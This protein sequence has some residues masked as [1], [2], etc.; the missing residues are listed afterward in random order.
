MID[1]KLLREDPKPFYE[2]CRKRGFGKEEVD[3]FLRLDKE[4]R[5][6]LKEIN[7]LRHEKNEISK[8]ISETL[9]RGEDPSSLK[10]KV[11]GLNEKIS[12]LEQEL[13]KTETS[14]DEISYSIPNV[15]HDSV[16]V[17][18][19]DEN[20]LFVKFVGKAKVF[21]DDLQDF[22]AATG[23]SGK[24]EKL[25]SRPESHVDL[26]DRLNIVDLER[27]G[28]IA[29]SRF[30]YLKNRLLKL[31]LALLNYAVDFISERGFSVVEPPFMMNHKSLSGST[32]LETFKDAVYKIE[33]EDLYLISTA[34]HPIASM[35]QDEILEEKEL[36]LRVGGISPCFRREA[37]AHG[38]DTKG[39]FR[40][41]QFFKV[42]QFVFCKTEDSWNF[43]EEILGNAEAIFQQLEIPYRVVNICS[44][45]LSV[46]NAKKYD[47]EGWFPAQGKFREL[48]SAS[49]NT[50]Y[51]GRSLSIRYRTKD[52]NKTVNT[53]NSTALATTRT[54]V[55]IMENNQLEDGSGFGI[56]KVLIPYTGF[57]TIGTE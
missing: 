55:A 57:D 54:L 38:K 36:P 45:E 21:Q 18:K 52:G 9:K 47:I 41:H 32:D 31:E 48:V 33:G 1:V 34:E 12:V 3:E 26:E 30:Y 49:N 35:L 7:E 5:E 16:P 22:L 4:W 17:C 10:E 2:S 37:G 11:K 42:E 53:L 27:A 44:G 25:N 46:L 51:Q 29:G 15:L 13:K 20:N 40:V 23:G 6:I 43:L 8:G 56:P 39:I 24:Y 14:R 28:K 50:D 19:G